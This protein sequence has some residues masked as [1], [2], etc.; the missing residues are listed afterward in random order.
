[1]K[2]IV[3]LS[4]AALIAAI[5]FYVSRFWSFSLWPRSGLFG[6]EELRPQGGL[7]GQW[8]R[9]TDFAPFELLIWAVG[10][11]LVLTVLQKLYDRLNP[12]PE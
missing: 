3:W 12:P 5:L 7:V 4:V 10:A 11:F 1:M 6:I 2:R 9:G 8:L